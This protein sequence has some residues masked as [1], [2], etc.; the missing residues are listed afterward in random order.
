M[1]I[2]LTAP[3]TALE[4]CQEGLLSLRSDGRFD[5]RDSALANELYGCR[6]D[7]WCVLAQGHHGDCDQNRQTDR[8]GGELPTFPREDVYLAA[9]VLWQAQLL[10]PAGCLYSGLKSSPTVRDK[11]S[12]ASK[13]TLSRSQSSRPWTWRTPP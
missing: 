2:A 10:P 9:G 4:A 13:L 11:T 12:G 5:M 3:A 8:A 7:D 1:S 6:L